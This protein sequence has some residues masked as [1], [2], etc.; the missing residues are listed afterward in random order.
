MFDHDTIWEFTTA[1]SISFGEGA[2]DEL[3]GRLRER[4]VESAL[5]VCD[6]G[7]TEAGIV[8]GLTDDDAVEYTLFDEVE[9]EPPLSVF[10]SA[11]DRAQAVDPDAVVGVGGGSSLDVAKTAGAL[12]PHGGDIMDYVAEPTGGGQSVPGEGLPTVAMPTT[13]GTGSETTPV[14]VISLPDRDMKIGI[15]SRHLYPDLAIVDPL[16][17]VSLPPGP[18]AAAGMDALAHAVEGYVTRPYDARERPETAADR[19]DYCGR[20][21]L[22]D[23]LLRRAVELVGDNLRTAVYNGEDVEARRSMSLA[24]LIA[25][26]GFSN[27]GLGAAHAIAMAAGAE[28]HTPHG[29]T[30]AA[31]L[32]AVMRYNAPGATNRYAEIADILGADT[33]DLTERDAAEQTAAQVAALADDIGTPSGLSEL[34][35]EASD[36]DRLADRTM[37][38]Q[39]LLVGNPRRVDRDD[40]VAICQRSL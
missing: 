16:L 10:E 33:G 7:I 5:V 15:S 24:S 1:E 3:G 37:D 26:M 40:V 35:I 18:T 17:T 20:S 19:P 21:T 11:V 22:T 27:A 6:P 32:P 34:G 38:L 25:G 8:D 30:V 2:A 31:V 36:V 14:S 23:Q 13:S 12:A 29:E 4:D 9:P 28:Y 39:R